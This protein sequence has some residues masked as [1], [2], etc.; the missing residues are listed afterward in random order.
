MINNKKNKQ[1][2]INILAYVFLKLYTEAF[3][4]NSKLIDII[5]K[6]VYFTE[7]VKYIF[8]LQTVYHVY[9]IN[10]LEPQNHS[11]KPNPVYFKR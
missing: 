8:L 9:I 2:S 5:R 10:C 7:T 1:Q 4:L 11:L 3:I 6:Q